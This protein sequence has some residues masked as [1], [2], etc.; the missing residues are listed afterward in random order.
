MPTGSEQVKATPPT[1]T[2]RRLLA[3]APW[4]PD[5]VIAEV[6]ERS[7]NR[8]AEV[9]QAM[10]LPPARECQLTKAKEILAGT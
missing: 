5:A 2:L 6:T 9:R 1:S 10:G 4:L 8:V 7:R 3:E